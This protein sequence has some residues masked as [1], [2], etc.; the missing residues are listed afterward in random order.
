[1]GLPASTYKCEHYQHTL[2]ESLT[3]V[4]RG[5]HSDCQVIMRLL[6]AEA[7]SGIVFAR[8][9]VEAF[10]AEV[11][12]LWHNVIDTRLSTTLGNALGVR[13]ST[14][15]HLLAALYACG[16][17]NARIVLDGPEIPVMDGSALPYMTVLQKTGALRQSAL[18]RAILIKKPV[19]VTEQDKYAGFIPSP[20][21]W[22]NIE[23]D[24]ASQAIGRQQ[25]SLP[26][27]P[28]TF[29]DQLAPA[30]TFGFDEQID[31]LRS[32]G[33]AKGGSLRNAVLIKD[34]RVMN[35]GG[36]RFPDE[37]VRHKALDCIGDMALAGARIAGLFKGRRTG[38]QINNAL[39]R[40]LMVREEAWEYITLAEAQD[41]WHNRIRAAAA[42]D[43]MRD[44]PRVAHEPVGVQG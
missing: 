36:L 17:D 42:F 2:S 31:T 5:L 33:L 27:N 22:I 20:I 16:I 34:D 7:N 44:A 43:G 28:Q 10:R 19:F 3:F 18:R 37:F 8:R 39:L 38:H 32:L 29:R 1:M 12:A 13:V 40:E 15:E 24:F 6:P 25:I 23:I 30:R 41:Y 35:E 14:V 21:P 26:V 9:D 4:G 11:P